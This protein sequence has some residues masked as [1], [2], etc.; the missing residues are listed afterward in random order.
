MIQIVHVYRNY[1]LL[2]SRRDF[3]T[4]LFLLRKTLILSKILDRFD[5]DVT[6]SNNQSITTPHRYIA[7][8]INSKIAKNMKTTVLTAF[9]TT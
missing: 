7:A 9:S 1:S 5:Y 2:R 6:L 3:L 8:T 4:A